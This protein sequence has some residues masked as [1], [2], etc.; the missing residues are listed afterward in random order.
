MPFPRLVKCLYICLHLFLAFALIIIGPALL[1]VFFVKYEPVLAA[2]NIV[3][4]GVSGLE[5]LKI[6]K[7]VYAEEAEIVKR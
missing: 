5:H 4:L 7:R 6:A 2:A 3:F 1:M